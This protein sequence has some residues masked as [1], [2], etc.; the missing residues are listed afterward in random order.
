MT[1]LL[2]SF[3]I[4]CF[5]D[6]ID[7]LYDDPQGFLGEVNYS[8]IETELTE[9]RALAKEIG[10]DISKIVNEVATPF[11]VSRF[12]DMINKNRLVSIPHFQL[13]RLRETF[14]PGLPW[15]LAYNTSKE[16]NFN[17]ELL[18]VR[19]NDKYY[20]IG[21]PTK[22]IAQGCC[23]SYNKDCFHNLRPID[24]SYYLGAK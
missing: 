7:N 19:N 18:E 8:T 1:P 24:F 15:G 2:K 16:D 14:D 22:D 20:M 10:V 3:M 11:E 23:D 12:S 5:T 6:R 21:Y 4:Q 9:L 13:V 17:V